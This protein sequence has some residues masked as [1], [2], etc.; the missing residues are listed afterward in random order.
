MAIVQ[1]KNKHYYDNSKYN[2]CPHCKRMNSPFS[3]VVDSSDKTVAVFKP[4]S[5]EFAH[6][7]N[8]SQNSSDDNPQKDGRNI[9]AKE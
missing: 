6:I 7:S 2:E 9:Y 1:C 4:A 5:P 3:P 8:D